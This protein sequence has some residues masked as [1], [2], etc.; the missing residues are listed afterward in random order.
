MKKLIASIVISSALIVGGLFFIENN[1][2]LHD[3][4]A[5]ELHPGIFSSEE[6]LAGELHPG[7]F[8]SEEGLAGELHPGIFSSEEG[9]AGELHPG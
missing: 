8:S 7:I 6:G 4:L 2:Q 9:L 3:G 1:H 5:G